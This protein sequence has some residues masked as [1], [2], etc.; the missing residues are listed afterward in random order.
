MKKTIR[1][2]IFLVLAATIFGDNVTD[3]VKET[4]EFINETQNQLELSTN[5]NIILVIGSEQSDKLLL[6]HYVAGDYSKISSIESDGG[7]TEYRIFDGIDAENKTNGTRSEFLV[8]EMIVDEKENVY[9]ILPVFKEFQNETEEIASAFRAK[10]VIENANNV[11]IVLVVN[12]TFFIDDLDRLLTHTMKL[13]KNIDRYNN[14]VSLVVSNVPSYWRKKEWS[15]ETFEESVKNSTAKFLRSYR[16]VLQENGM[17]EAKIQ[18]IDILLSN[19][20]K[21]SVF[22]RP[23][24]AGAFNEIVEMVYGRWQIR[25]SILEQTPYTKRMQNDFDFP[26]SD[27]AQI[28]VANMARQTIDRLLQALIS[29]DK[30]VLS[31]LQHAIETSVEDIHH[32]KSFFRNVSLSPNYQLNAYEEPTLQQLAEMNIDVNMTSINAKINHIRQLEKNLNILKTLA[33]T[34]I[35]FSIRE[36]IAESSHTRK[37]VKTEYNWYSFMVQVYDF[38]HNP[39]VQQNVSMYNVANIS[40]WGRLNRP[41]GLEIGEHNFDEFKKRFLNYT[42]DEITPSRL[43]EL[44]EMID[45]ALLSSPK[46]ECDGETLTIKGMNLNTSHIQPSKCPMNI[47]KINVFAV[48]TFCIDHDLSLIGYRALNIFANKW[49]I[50]KATTFNLKGT[51]A[52]AQRLRRPSTRG[53]GGKPGDSGSNSGNFFGLTNEIVNGNALTV[54]LIGG[55]GGQGQDGTSSNDI[56]ATF[57]RQTLK[58]HPTDAFEASEVISIFENFLKKGG[59]KTEYISNQSDFSQ[60]DTH[61]GNCTLRFLIYPL[62]CCGR[63]GMGGSGKKI[64]RVCRNYRLEIIIVSNLDTQ[65]RTK[66]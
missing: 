40:D 25:K 38:F 15:L 48:D 50:L 32:R 45:I 30:D 33:Q 56:E 65:N 18:W 29:I 28:I 20:S 16:S 6:L 14:S 3:T 60:C 7:E 36:W 52:K 9:Y 59:Y 61:G 47:S 34:N 53:T 31:A 24:T 57:T 5:K 8:S 21:M 10:S 13:I 54:N 39:E 1:S 46:Y 23:D 41:Q 22:W 37:Y 63:T 55:I 64:G 66:V 35:T 27:A 12:C 17:N 62:E 58:T 43:K 49:E 11:K 4:F 51:N 2:L 26:L 42:V 44:N 19:L